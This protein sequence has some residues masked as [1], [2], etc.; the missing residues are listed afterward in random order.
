MEISQS[1]GQDTNGSC[2]FIVEKQDQSLNRSYPADSYQIANKILEGNRNLEGS[3]RSSS[4][5]FGNY[6]NEANSF[7]LQREFKDDSYRFTQKIYSDNE[8]QEQIIV[9]EEIGTYEFI[10]NSDY[11][12]RGQG[13][14][15]LNI[16]E[17]SLTGLTK[18]G[19]EALKI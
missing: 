10:R 16:S 15:T 6:L 17:V 19:I 18:E 8:C 12:S 5:I 13:S 14:L 7:L 4:Y 3:C 9:S 11:F 2:S 1:F